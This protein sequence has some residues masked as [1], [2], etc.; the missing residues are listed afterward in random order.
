M[1]AKYPLLRRDLG[2]IGVLQGDIVDESI[3]N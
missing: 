1:S 3:V 2:A